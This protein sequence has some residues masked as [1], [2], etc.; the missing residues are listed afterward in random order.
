M[1]SPDVIS[2][3]LVNTPV[4]LLLLTLC[5]LFNYCHVPVPYPKLCYGT[6]S[7]LVLHNPYVPFLNLFLP[8]LLSLSF[9]DSFLLHTMHFIC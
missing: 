9:V 2:L 5:S 6:Q 4:A 7:N 3:A 8:F 1:F